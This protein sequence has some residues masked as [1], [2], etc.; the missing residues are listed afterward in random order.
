[1]STVELT[2]DGHAVH[3]ATG[4]A[5][6]D[7]AA[8]CVVFLHGAGMDHTAFAFQTRYFAF[9]GR[10]CLALD[11]PGHGQSRG[12]TLPTIAAMAD[13][14]VRVMDAAQVETAALVGHSMGS[15][16]ALSCAARHPT[17]VRALGL[18]GTALAMRV[19]PALLD[20]AAASDPA[21]T[22]MVNLWGFG[23]RAGRGGAEAPGVWMTGAGDRL[24]ARSAPGVLAA[25]LA[26]CDA[27]DSAAVDAAAVA[28]PTRIVQGARDMMTPLKS[29][30]ALAAVLPGATLSDIPEAGHMTMIE[31]AEATRVALTSVV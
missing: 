14:V 25:D 3:A 1:M 16:V 15:L 26:A 8:P 2:V 31:S 30:R 19:S 11:F 20:A 9:R 24:L 12:P 13:W 21:A 5:P 18:I 6:V 17:R 28:C 7:R 10:R 23:P 27:Y 29:A 4:G 22:A